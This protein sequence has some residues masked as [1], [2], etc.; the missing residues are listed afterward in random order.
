M[1]EGDDG[2]V[3]GAVDGWAFRATCEVESVKQIGGIPPEVAEFMEPM[4]QLERVAWKS[5]CIMRN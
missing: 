4:I 3:V 5:R 2:L 1:E